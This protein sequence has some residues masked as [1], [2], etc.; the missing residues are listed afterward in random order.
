MNPLDTFQWVMLCFYCK[1]VHIKVD[2]LITYRK[3]VNKLSIEIIEE[4]KAV[5]EA[6]K[7]MGEPVRLKDLV[8]LTKDRV[9]WKNPKALTGQMK[10]Y[11]RYVP[12]ITKDDGFGMYKYLGEEKEVKKK[13][14]YT[15]RVKPLS[16]EIEEQ[17]ALI[18]ETTTVQEATTPTE[19]EMV[20]EETETTNGKDESVLE[21]TEKDQEL[22]ENFRNTAMPE[23][24]KPKR[25]P[26]TGDIIEGKVTGIEDY[27]V[28]VCNDD[29]SIQGLVHITNVSKKPVTSLNKH[30]KIGDTVKAK[31]INIKHSGKIALSTKDFSLPDYFVN[32]TIADKLKPIAEKMAGGNVGMPTQN[33]VPTQNKVVAIESQ[34][35]MAK[36][37]ESGELKEV[38]KFI[39]G[40]TG[41]VSDNAKDK[42]I[43]LIEESGMFKFTMALA[44]VQK[45]FEVDV[46]MMLAKAIEDKMRGGL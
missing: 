23:F 6:L 15:R 9:Q 37:E 11:M 17:M 3:E 38:Y 39:Q 24:I 40:V 4:A 33:N 19:I 2:G 43:G 27:G 34:Q 31:I 42:I 10:S 5:E 46:S 1:P 12:T 14:K 44:E 26:K 18:E 22:L 16:Q 21:V 28:F 30:F 45:D 7:V 36:R 32:E 20:Q 41:I 8:E 25:T 13:R 29:E 35:R